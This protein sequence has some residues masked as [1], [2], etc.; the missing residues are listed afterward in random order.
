[1]EKIAT[2][3]K[4]ARFNDPSPLFRGRFFEGHDGFKDF[5]DEEHEV[6]TM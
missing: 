5:G 6:A 3:D 4:K 1:M 2:M